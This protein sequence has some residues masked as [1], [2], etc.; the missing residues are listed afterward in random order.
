[1]PDRRDGR[2][3]QRPTISDQSRHIKRRRH[4]IPRPRHRRI[5]HRRIPR[6]RNIPFPRPLLEAAA[7]RRRPPRRR[8]LPFAPAPGERDGGSRGAREVQQRAAG[9]S[10]AVQDVVRKRRGSEEGGGGGGASGVLEG[11]AGD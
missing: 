7:P 1:M 8:I 6:P 11:E 5:H 10:A 2:R 9:V 4:G 3:Q